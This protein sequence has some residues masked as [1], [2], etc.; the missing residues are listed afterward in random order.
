[1]KKYKAREGIVLAEVCDQFIL[2]ASKEAR[3]FCPYTILINETSAYIWKKL[4]NKGEYLSEDQLLK[5]VAQE[6]Q[7]EDEAYVR[8][9]ISNFLE[10]MI[11][12]GYIIVMEEND[13]K[14]ASF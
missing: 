6:Y 8:E 7:I 4:D 9:T 14:G 1:M 11:K 12:R 5:E 10:D 2:A 13:E 3:E